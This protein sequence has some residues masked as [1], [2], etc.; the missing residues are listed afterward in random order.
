MFT[1]QFVLSW[2]DIIFEE[3]SLGVGNFGQVVKATVKKD[4]ELLAS[5]VTKFYWGGGGGRA[6][7]GP[8]PPNPLF[9]P[10]ILICLKK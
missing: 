1:E 9:Y 6:P 10:G 3:V 7:R 5:A 2:S 8:P 4:N